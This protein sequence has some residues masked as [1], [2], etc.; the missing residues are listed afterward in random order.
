MFAFGSGASP[1]LRECR[2]RPLHTRLLY[3]W[4]REGR[5]GEGKG[6][7]GSVGGEGDKVVKWQQ[8]LSG[9]GNQVLSRH[10]RSTVHTHV[11]FFFCKEN[12]EMI[13]EQK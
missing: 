3:L 7:E 4:G 5:G 8:I 13:V 12:D 9:I 10:G 2:S 6:R 1:G 11:S